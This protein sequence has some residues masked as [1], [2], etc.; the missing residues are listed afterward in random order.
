M[1]VSLGLRPHSQ[2][3]KFPKSYITNQ[4]KKMASMKFLNCFHNC[5][6]LVLDES[7]NCWQIIHCVGHLVSTWSPTFHQLSP[8]H[9]FF[10]PPHDWCSCVWLVGGF[11]LELN[12]WVV[13][14]SA[15]DC[16]LYFVSIILSMLIKSLSVKIWLTPSPHI[17][18]LPEIGG[19][20]N[21]PHMHRMPPVHRKWSHQQVCGT[22][23][24]GLIPNP[25]SC[26]VIILATPNKA[27]LLHLWIDMHSVLQHCVP[28]H[29]LG[30]DL[31][32]FKRFLIMVNCVNTVVV[33]CI[34]SHH[35]ATFGS[36]I[37]TSSVQ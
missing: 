1:Y 5:Q 23:F 4:F 19:E 37:S 11:H 32:S 33:D 35:V 30:Q 17:L 16:S 22:T 14:D 6:I 3:K 27:W 2:L 13:Q 9:R 10:L 25:T 28:Q 26:C 29:Y 31:N 12:K 21:G 15:G 24:P 8:S 36:S 7:F 34:V 18:F 20:E